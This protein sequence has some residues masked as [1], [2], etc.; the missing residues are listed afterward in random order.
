MG[1]VIADILTEFKVATVD[2][3]ISKIFELEVNDF[4]LEGVNWFI[5]SL[6]VQLTK[7]I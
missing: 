5:L 6:L 3:D 7:E 2:F 4:S 1:Q